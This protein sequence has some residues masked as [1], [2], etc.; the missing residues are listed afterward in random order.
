MQSSYIIR[1]YQAE[2][3]PAAIQLYKNLMEHHSDIIYW[4]PGPE[5]NW[6]NVCC[7]FYKDLMIAKAQIETI[8][9][10]PADHSTN[11]SHLIFFNM[12]LHSKWE[13]DNDLRKLLYK[14]IL[15]KAKLKKEKLPSLFPVKLCAGNFASEAKENAYL[16]STGFEHFKSL[17]WMRCKLD[18]LVPQSTLKF[19]VSP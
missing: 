17:Y 13:D 2:D 12:K 10:I 18:N 7:V 9:I 15:E 3:K 16:K 19:Q 5:N 4:W 6:E 14:K 8:N 11:A 1:S